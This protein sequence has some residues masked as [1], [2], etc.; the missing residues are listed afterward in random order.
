MTSTSPFRSSG[1][2]GCTT[3]RLFNAIFANEF[4]GY[5][6]LDGSGQLQRIPIR[7]A[8]AAM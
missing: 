8:D 5:A 1:C 6:L 4:N 3:L 7:K 2:L